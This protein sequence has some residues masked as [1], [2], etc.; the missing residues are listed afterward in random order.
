MGTLLTENVF[1]Q[2]AQS[3][4]SEQLRSCLHTKMRGLDRMGLVSLFVIQWAMR[5]QQVSRAR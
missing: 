3:V 1:W 2:V 5:C 4:D